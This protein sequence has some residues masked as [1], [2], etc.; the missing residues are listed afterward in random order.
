M[1]RMTG[2]DCAVMCN[3][4]NTHTHADTHTRR[5]THTNTHIDLGGKAVNNFFFCTSRISDPVVNN[6]VM[7]YFQPKCIQNQLEMVMAHNFPAW[8]EKCG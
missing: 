6:N 1:T 3:L 8:A 4:I 2:P 5:H 7:D